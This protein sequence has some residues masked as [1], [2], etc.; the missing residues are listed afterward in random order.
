MPWNVI[1]QLHDAR[2]DKF[3][4][5]L[6]DD[7]NTDDRPHLVL[8]L[9]LSLQNPLQPGVITRVRIASKLA[10][11][12]D[13]N[14]FRFMNPVLAS[15]VK[16]HMLLN[17]DNFET[18]FD[19]FLPEGLNRK[20]WFYLDGF[21]APTNTNTAGRPPFSYDVVMTTAA[22][23]RVSAPGNLTVP[24]GPTTCLRYQGLKGSTLMTLWS[25]YTM[26]YTDE[27]EIFMNIQFIHDLAPDRFAKWMK[28]SAKFGG[29]H[30]DVSVFNPT[31]WNQMKTN[32][33]PDGDILTHS[34]TYNDTQVVISSWEYSTS[35]TLQRNLMGWRKWI[36]S[37]GTIICFGM[38]TGA[39]KGPNRN[40]LIV[41]AY[42][43]FTTIDGLSQQYP[44]LQ[45]EAGGGYT[46]PSLPELPTNYRLLR[47]TDM[48]PTSVAIEG[49]RNPTATDNSTLLAIFAQYNHL[50]I[51]LCPQFTIID[52][53]SVTGI[54][55][56]RYLQEYRVFVVAV[57]SPSAYLVIPQ[58]T[59]NM[60]ISKISIV[61]RTTD[62]QITNT[63]PAPGVEP[64]EGV[65]AMSFTEV[66]ALLMLLIAVASLVHQLN[67]RK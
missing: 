8:F 42:S 4:R 9:L 49:F 33:V 62:F 52:N 65:M 41:E 36:T 32:I 20:I 56:V 48:P 3:Y 12:A 25:D 26:P 7:N 60:T 13:S 19:T 5:L 67:Q 38:T 59:R 28:E 35:T 24:Q 53:R 61:E 55:R 37:E 34:L 57:A 58:E 18:Q 6:A 66:C 31:V 46:S 23:Y 64:G 17:Q 50:P 47:I 51:T 44:I 43:S 30:A 45:I 16:S 21:K 11:A 15:P 2:Q 40:P 54:L 1:H 10:N 39:V 14:P 27:T 63:P 22:G 29:F